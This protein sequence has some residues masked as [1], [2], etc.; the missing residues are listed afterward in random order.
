MTGAVLAG[1]MRAFPARRGLL[2]LRLAAA[3]A[4]AAAIKSFVI[5]PLTG[6]FAGSFEDFSA[7]IGAAR[8][9]AAGASPYAH[10]DA[11]TVVMSGFTYPP[12]AAMLVRPL[13]LLGDRQ[14]LSVWLA[15]CLAATVA[16]TVLVARISLPESW[17]RVELA[18]L[19]A[20]AF[21]PAT[22]NY[23][24]GQMNPCILLLLA[25]AFYAYVR[26][27]ELL[28]GVA[29]G[30]G[31]GIKIAP[32]VLLLLL[33]RR[34][35]WRGAFAGAGVAVATVVLGLLVIGT[36][37]TR[38]FL[39]SVLPT[40]NR[41]TGWVYNLSLTGAI[42]RAANHAVLHVQSDSSALIQGASLAAAAVLLLAM[43]TVVRARCVAAEMRG[44]EFGLGV[45]V[46]LLAGSISWFPHYTHL[47]I[48][49][50]AGL[51]LVA[52]HG[53]HRERAVALAGGAALA[54]F[55]VLAPL[56]IST[57]T[58]QGI[59]DAGRTAAWWPLLQLA[60]IPTAV[61]LGFAV[62]LMRRLRQ[63]PLVGSSGSMPVAATAVHRS[64]AS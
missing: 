50:F 36:G 19:A 38:F 39:S 14:A 7:Y 34:R 58:I 18:V 1:P 60:S 29:I 57:L 32:L 28:A 23:W 9:M 10:F 31:A 13:A 8:S 64:R 40:L 12:F 16:A 24:H 2:L 35:W 33:L 6:R 4:A 42:S 17:P 22:Y 63:R 47:L 56:V 48:P 11:S 51:G 27:R 49:L 45:T 46:S 52:R 25:L 30:L 62:V 59:A 5:D 41:P 43:C 21:A 53:L 44:I 55:G 20:L 54:V 37:P 26:D 3:A 15:L 61:A